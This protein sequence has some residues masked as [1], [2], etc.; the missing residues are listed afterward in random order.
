[1]IY[2]NNIPSLRNPESISYNFDHRIEKIE[3]INGTTAQNYGHVESGDS[4]SLSCVFS[5]ANYNLLKELWINNQFVSFTDEAGNIFYNLRLV[6]KSIKRVS[7][8]P[9][10]VTLDF[11][12]W[13]C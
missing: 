6:F 7:K 10:Y 11:D 4:F 12:L 2:I 5:V 9:N 13:R 8:F 1:M 3:L